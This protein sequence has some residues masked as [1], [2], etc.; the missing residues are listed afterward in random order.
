MN[1]K[2]KGRGRGNP[3]QAEIIRPGGG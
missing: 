1:E 2:G 3:P